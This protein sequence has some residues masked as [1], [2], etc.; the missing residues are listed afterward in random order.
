M[1]IEGLG[2]LFLQK[3]NISTFYRPTVAL[4]GANLLTHPALFY[5]INKMEMRSYLLWGEIVVV[6]VESIVYWKWGRRNLL[7]SFA[8]SLVLNGASWQLGKWFY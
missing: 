5:V 3:C 6:M 2:I 7:E 4:M 1:L 8:S